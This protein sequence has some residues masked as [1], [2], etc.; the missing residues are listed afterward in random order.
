MHFISREVKY[1][2]RRFSSIR[3]SEGENP[4]HISVI[5]RQPLR[6]WHTAD[7]FS[8]PEWRRVWKG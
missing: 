4:S 7:M 3:D 5:Q 1:F 2:P 6:F 8:V